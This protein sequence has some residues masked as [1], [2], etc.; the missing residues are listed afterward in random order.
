MLSEIDFESVNQEMASSCNLT[1]AEFNA[2]ERQLF[3]LYDYNV[4][5]SDEEFQSQ[6]QL[7]NK[8]VFGESDEQGDE[9]SSEQSELRVDDDDDG[10]KV[11]GDDVNPTVN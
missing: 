9:M 2:L 8:T 7:L 1:L 4:G 10:M 5:V 3:S 11:N 6:L